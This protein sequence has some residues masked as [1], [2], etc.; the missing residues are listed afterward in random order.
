MRSHLKHVKT[1][2]KKLADGT[3]KEY[4]YHR[5][6]WKR[7][8]GEPGTDAFLENYIQAGKSEH[9]AVTDT[10]GGIL[11]A[12]QA[13]PEFR[14][15]KP[16]TQADYKKQIAKIGPSMRR[17]TIG[18]LEDR[19]VRRHFIRFRDGLSKS[20]L[21]QADYA[22]TVLSRTLSWA[23]DQYLIEH[24]HA[25]GIKRL[26]KS[27]RADKVWSDEQIEAFLKA[28]HQT[29]ADVFL[30]GLLTGQRQGDLLRLS[31][32]AYDGE[33]LTVRQGKTGKVVYAP[34]TALLRGRLRKLDKKSTTILTNRSGKPWT[35]DGFRSMFHK[36][37]ADAGVSEMR[38]H[39][40]RGTFCTR[41][42]E[43]GATDSEIN[44]ITG[45]S[46][47]SQLQSTYLARTKELARSA[48]AK[49]EAKTGTDL[50]TEVETASVDKIVHLR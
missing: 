41:L 47:G 18:S 36:A 43:C 27:N 33:G 31:W 11:K 28:A 13:S 22:I 7:I 1:A 39:D 24:N 14:T 25:S 30:L 42:A 48:I 23:V 45:H 29:V 38:F 49:L 15:K 9:A 16:R 40:L 34:C 21:K 46:D 20:S 44:A 6:T 50:E 35:A 12:Y 17:L 26:Y 37:K 32:N 19:G 2:R 4:Y 5:R 3:V 8:E 10:L